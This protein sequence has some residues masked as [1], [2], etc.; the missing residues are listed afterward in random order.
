MSAASPCP[1]RPRILF[2]DD[3]RDVAVTLSKL[4]PK[5]SFECRF[6]D[7]GEAALTRL[8]AEVFDLAVV[9][10]RMPPDDWGGLWLLRELSER[11]LAIDTLV[12]SGEGGQSETIEAMR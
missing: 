5:G 7:D 11:G 10:L 8:S 9:D 4:L 12:L 3:Q 1:R 6:A 2:V